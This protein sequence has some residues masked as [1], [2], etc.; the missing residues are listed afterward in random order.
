MGFRLMVITI[1]AGVFVAGCSSQEVPVAEE[2]IGYTDQPVLRDDFEETEG[3][4]AS[5]ASE[6]AAKP[7]SD[8]L[9]PFS[10]QVR[11]ID[12]LVSGRDRL[13]VK[14][15]PNVAPS[16]EEV[17]SLEAEEAVEALHHQGLTGQEICGA[18]PG[19][20]DFAKAEE[21]T[22]A[23]VTDKNTTP[24]AR[25]VAAAV[26][27]YYSVVAKT[28]NEPAVQGLLCIAQV[29]IQPKLEWKWADL[30]K[31]ISSETSVSYLLPE[32]VHVVGLMTGNALAVACLQ[33]L[34]YG[35]LSLDDAPIATTLLLQ[36]AGDRWRVSVAEDFSSA[37]SS[38]SSSTSSPVVGSSHCH[39]HLSAV[40]AEFTDDMAVT[41]ERWRFGQWLFTAEELKEIESTT[42]EVQL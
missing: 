16:D 9:E 28:H 7:P 13:S 36:W 5:E 15:Y 39:Q 33:P 26:W 24:T 35:Q 29:T 14:L 30:R 32:E 11:R 4:A 25:D 12:G 20:S 23:V 8:T 40:R 18:P 37:S 2:E 1:L 34:A 41:G 17:L 10:P 38:T 22:Y 31:L 6:N 42:E 27:Q 21:N 19:I 3:L